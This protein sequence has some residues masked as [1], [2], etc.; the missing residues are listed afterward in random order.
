MLSRDDG[1]RNSTRLM[2]EILMIFVLYA[3]GASTVLVW[4]TLLEKGRVFGPQIS[5][6]GIEYVAIPG[7]TFFELA[8][9]HPNLVIFDVHADGGA[10]GGSE[11]V[12][13]WLPISAVDLPGVLKWLPPASRVVFCCKD[14]TEH[15]DTQTKTILLLL[16][17]GIAYF[18]DDS[19]LV[20]AKNSC[21]STFATLDANQELRKIT[22]RET[23]RRL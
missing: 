4:S 9:Q 7:Y 10:S 8:E 14:A 21:A 1:T 19:S 18:L 16:G 2:A 20:P 22:T 23:R 3:I 13:H 6:R 5:Q 17:I 11:F 15:L 12:S